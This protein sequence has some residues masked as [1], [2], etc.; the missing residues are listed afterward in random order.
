VKFGRTRV[1]IP[2]KR[3]LNRP[4]SSRIVWISMKR[5]RSGQLL[6]SH[7]PNRIQVTK[8][9]AS[10]RLVRS[11]ALSW[12][13]ARGGRAVPTACSS[14]RRLA[15]WSELIASSHRG[16]LTTFFTKEYESAG[17]VR[18]QSYRAAYASPATLWSGRRGAATSLHA[19]E[20][21]T[22]EHV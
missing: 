10:T 14:A 20:R 12:A 11:S 19:S 9:A 6:K 4:I 18:Q 16:A 22:T 15:K 21:A 13:R 5:P 7:R 3:Q 1:P 17:C 8:L 2:N